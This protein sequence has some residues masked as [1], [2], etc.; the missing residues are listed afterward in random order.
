MKINIKTEDFKESELPKVNKA[1]ECLRLVTSN[2][3][4]W[5]RCKNI[6]LRE[7]IGERSKWANKSTEEI[8]AHI[9]TGAEVLRPEID[10]EIDIDLKIFNPNWRSRNVVGRTWTDVIW[11]EINRKFFRLYTFIKVAGNMFHEWLHKMGF[12]H[13][14]RSTKVRKWSVCY[15][16][17]KEF[18]KFAIELYNAQDLEPIPEEAPK[19]RIGFWA[20]IWRLV[21]FKW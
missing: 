3:E 20:K 6:P 18:I 10:Q 1:A 17:Q 4:F 5:E 2:P 11:Q 8:I 15:R 13:D 7:L 9:K 16:F 21:S 12:K 19:K 14:F